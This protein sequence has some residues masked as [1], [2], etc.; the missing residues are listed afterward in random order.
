MRSRKLLWAV[1]LAVLVAVRVFVLW[2]RPDRI[3]EENFS[4]IKVG[5]SREEVHAIL[6]SPDD[7]RTV[8]TEADI[9]GPTVGDWL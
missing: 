1:G 6:G 3:T 2:S 9:W 4:R 8:E 7:Y 5:M